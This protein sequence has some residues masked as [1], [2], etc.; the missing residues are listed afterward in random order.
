MLTRFAGAPENKAALVAGVPMGRLGPSEELANAIVFIASDE[1]S[2]ITGHS[3]T[4]TAV[5]PLTDPVRARRFV[6]RPDKG[7]SPRGTLPTAFAASGRRPL[8][9]ASPSAAAI[10]SRRWRSALTRL[11]SSCS[12][13]GS[14]SFGARK[15]FGG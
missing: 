2:F 5:T 9:I 15:Q 10:S 12:L 3:S 11:A 13:T 4:S 7:R 1:A 14:P 8:S 6:P